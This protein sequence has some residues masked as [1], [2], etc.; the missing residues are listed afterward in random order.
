MRYVSKLFYGS[1]L[2]Q[3]YCFKSLYI[4]SFDFLFGCCR[5]F[6]KKRC[7]F[8]ETILPK[9]GRMLAT[10]CCHSA[11]IQRESKLAAIL[12]LPDSTTQNKL[13]LSLNTPLLVLSLYIF[14]FSSFVLLFC[15]CSMF[16]VCKK[17]KFKLCLIY[18]F[19]LTISQ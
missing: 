16:F 18:L 13:V 9:W 7:Y 10:T 15:F 17:C 8:F 19:F 11:S 6:L 12:L 14:W 4:L 2:D 1:E 5:N 3:V